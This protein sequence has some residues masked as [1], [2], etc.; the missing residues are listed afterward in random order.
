MEPIAVLLII[1]AISLVNF[2]VRKLQGAPPDDQMLDGGTPPPTQRGAPLPRQ[3]AKEE[4][5]RERVRRFMDALGIPESEL[6]PRPIET[7][8]EPPPLAPQPR[9]AP[10][11]PR[12]AE[13]APRWPAQPPAQAPAHAPVPRPAAPPAVA[14]AVAV[15]TGALPVTKVEVG[16]SEIGNVAAAKQA[17]EAYL[18]APLR[19]QTPSSTG[20]LRDL[21]RKP[22]SVRTAILLREILGPPK[23]LQPR[24]EAHSF[25]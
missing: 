24:I 5:D 20:E 2:I 7:R 16:L 12:R 9:P 10:L 8:R 21:L 25:P 17:A 13:S 14:A 18:I 15:A 19:A 1:G 3:V 11:P 6:P 4:D 22:E 23:G